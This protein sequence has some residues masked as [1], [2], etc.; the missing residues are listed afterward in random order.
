MNPPEESELDD[1]PPMFTMASDVYAFGMT[2]LEV[3]IFHL[4]YFV[5]PIRAQ[6]SLSFVY[7]LDFFWPSSL[8]QE[9]KR[10][11]S[12]FRRPGR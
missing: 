2:I 5:S 9:K 12:H 4:F 11:R 10:Q 3:C 7:F 6:K 8:Q 1:P